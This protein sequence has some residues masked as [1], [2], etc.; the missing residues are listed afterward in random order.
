MTLGTRTVKVDVLPTF[1]A[2]ANVGITLT[3]LYL[4][5]A[6]P[7][8]CLATTMNEMQIGSAAGG[9]RLVIFRLGGVAHCS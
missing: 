8:M 3:A 2:Y 9:G 4:L 6:G 1:K 5:G 7:S